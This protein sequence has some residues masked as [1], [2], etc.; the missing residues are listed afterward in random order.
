MQ[1]DYEIYESGD[2]YTRDE[3]SEGSR[4]YSPPRQVSIQS[5]NQITCN[6]CFTSSGMDTFLIS[7]IICIFES[8][9][10]KLYEICI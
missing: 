1:I 10:Y 2:C 5:S 9:H 7:F 6:F 3:N 8:S 4:E